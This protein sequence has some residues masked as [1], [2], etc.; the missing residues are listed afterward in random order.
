MGKTEVVTTCDHLEKLSL[1]STSPFYFV[2][3]W[4]GSIYVL[5][6]TGSS[7]FSALRLM[8]EWEKRISIARYFKVY[9]RFTHCLHQRPP[10]DF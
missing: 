10:F 5:R 3:H 2:P 8:N 4:N 9:R 7:I 6:H 1:A